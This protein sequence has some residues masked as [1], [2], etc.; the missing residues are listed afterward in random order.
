MAEHLWEHQHPYSCHEGN[1]F[2]NGQHETFASWDEFA[3]PASFDKE[4]NA[5][6]NVLYNWD[7]DLNFLFRWDWKKA[8]PEDYW[9]K[10]GDPDDETARFEEDRKTDTL[11]LFFM[12]QRKA[13]NS[14]AEVKI[15]EADEPA[16]REW[17]AKK[18]EYMRK[19]WEP[20]LD[21]S[22]VASNV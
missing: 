15:T 2:K 18:A 13:R 3:Q 16:V 5:L 21:G 20:L 22:E 19:I 6:G 7:D 17:L 12:H 1:Y 4:F 14:S 8:D 10:P 11:L 9:L